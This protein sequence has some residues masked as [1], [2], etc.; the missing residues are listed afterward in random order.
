MFDFLIPMFNLLQLLQ[1][2]TPE[3][4]LLLAEH[5]VH[6]GKDAQRPPCSENSN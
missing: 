1:L 6:T 5:Q 2:Y 3:V 4:Q